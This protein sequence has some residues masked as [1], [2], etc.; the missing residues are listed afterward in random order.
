MTD[1]T[2]NYEKSVKGKDESKDK[3]Q[4]KDK[5]L[6]KMNINKRRGNWTRREREKKWYK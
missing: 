5:D 6:K 4:A 2:E 1:M 3:S